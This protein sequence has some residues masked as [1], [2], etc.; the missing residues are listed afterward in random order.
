MTI[1]FHICCYG[2]RLGLYYV[3]LNPIAAVSSFLRMLG[4]IRAGGFGAQ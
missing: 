1:V 2:L 4:T 3:G